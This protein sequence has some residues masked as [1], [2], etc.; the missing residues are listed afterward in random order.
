M[1]SN[2]QEMLL[3]IYIENGKVKIH[4]FVGGVFHGED[5]LFDA[6]VFAI[7]SSI[8]K[9]FELQKERKEYLETVK[10]RIELLL[11]IDLE[12]HP[13]FKSNIS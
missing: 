7:A 2:E 11:E 1:I 13:L 5:I 8:Y 10:R 6:F 9:R 12:K 4:S 3:S